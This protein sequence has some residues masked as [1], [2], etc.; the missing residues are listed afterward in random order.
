MKPVKKPVKKPGKKPVAESSRKG[1][2]VTLAQDIMADL[3]AQ[4]D[5]IDYD[6]KGNRVISVGPSRK[7]K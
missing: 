2:R 7:R 1:K 5:Y 3:D 4:S 6:A